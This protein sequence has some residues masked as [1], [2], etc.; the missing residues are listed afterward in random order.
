MKGDALAQ[1]QLYDMH[2]TRWF[3]LCLRYGKSKS[4]AED[5]LQ[6]GLIRIF[7]DL[8]QYDERR[9]QFST[10]SNRLIV[11]AALHFLKKNQW[12]KSLLDIDDVHMDNHNSDEIYSKIAAKELTHLIQGLPIGYRL[13]FN[14]YVIEGY[15]H[16]EIAK[17]LGIKEGTSK[18]QLFK[19]KR[20]LR[21]KLDLQLTKY[22]YGQEG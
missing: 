16:K 3:M 20:E 10:W 1:R 21:S 19:A 7:K 13:V 12:H 17:E 5:I 9:S 22:S 8:H 14:M 2:R 11:H 4:E 6:E 15:T 18:S